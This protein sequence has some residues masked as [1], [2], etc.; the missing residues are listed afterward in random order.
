MRFF[1]DD[2]CLWFSGAYAPQIRRYREPKHL[3]PTHEPF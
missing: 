1:I 3:G 2:L